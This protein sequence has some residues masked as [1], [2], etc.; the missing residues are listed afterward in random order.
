MGSVGYTWDVK[1]PSRD[2]AGLPRS[3]TPTWKAHSSCHI[4]FSHLLSQKDVLQREN[5]WRSW[6]IIQLACAS[7]TSTMNSQAAGTR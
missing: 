6:A 1:P 5:R 3:Q 2:V 7:Q 4:F